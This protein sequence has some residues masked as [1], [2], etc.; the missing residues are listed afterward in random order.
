[1]TAEG[2]LEETYRSRCL[3]REGEPT[4]DWQSDLCRRRSCGKSGLPVPGICIDS[5]KMFFVTLSSGSVNMKV[6]P[7][8]S[9]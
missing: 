8:T 5:Y 3:R 6:S 2:V 4:G 9:W 1:M 7:A